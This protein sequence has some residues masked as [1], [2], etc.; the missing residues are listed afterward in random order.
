MPTNATPTG[1]ERLADFIR[2][3]VEPIVVEWIDFARTRT[4]ASENM[5]KL[6]LRD[7]IEEILNFVADDLESPQST[8]E[9]VKKSRGLGPDDSVFTQ[10]AAELHAELR[11][12][13]GF[14]ID[15]MVSEYR[16]L[17]ASVV[18]QWIAHKRILADTDL[19]DLTRF[20]EAI[21]QAVAESVAHYTDSVNRSRSLF[22][23]IL[24]HDL[25]NPIGAATMAA[26]HMIKRGGIDPNQTLIA[27]QI[28]SATERAAQI[29]ND[30]LDITRSAFG[31]DMPIAKVPMDMGQLGL[32][33]AEEMRTVS[34]GRVI[35]VDIDGETSG[36]WDKVRIGQMLSNLMG[37]ALQYSHENSPV[38]VSIAGQ[39]DD[40]LISV[41][42]DGDPIPSNKIDGIFDSFTRAQYGEIEGAGAMNLGLGLYI[43]KRI[44]LAHRGNIGVV[45]TAQAGTTI[46]VRLPRQWRG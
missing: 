11:L 1:H 41:H 13:D 9:Q 35:E 28:V 44:V 43:V 42:N 18:K 8:R 15:Q 12:S 39:G 26:R 20:N 14:D 22:L 25:R 30:L 27:S 34:N 23:G 6:A 16:A 2:L 33:L 10:S 5:T 17:R 38:L 45:S 7:H 19:E 37:N 4:P 36:E 46:T 24:G 3:N 21:D 40:L 31:T 29:I 32:Q